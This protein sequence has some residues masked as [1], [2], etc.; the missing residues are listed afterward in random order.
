MIHGVI[1]KGVGGFYYVKTSEGVI[2]C[3]ARGNF[4]EENI[5][6]L[7]GDKV[8][9]RISSEDNT[10]Y[11]D[12]ILKRKSQLTRPAVANVTQAIIVMSI[13]NPDINTWLLDRFIVMAEHENLDIVIA[14]NKVD[15]DLEGA[16]EIKKIYENIGYKVLATSIEEEKDIDELRNTLKNNT[17]VFAGPSGVGKSSLLNLIE[18]DYDLEIGEIS[19]RSRRGKH[20]TRHTELLFLKENTYVLDTPGF[21]S[22]DIGFIEDEQDL[23]NYF[24]EIHDY[25]KYCKFLNCVHENEPGCEVKK[26]VENS[27]ISKE[28]YKNYLSFLEEIRKSR[29][30]RY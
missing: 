4:R 29:I 9:I 15:L 23:D 27:K 3:R 30:G 25:G 11:I 1:T 19:T 6:P 22:L 16:L 24:L 8:K 10:G 12:E 21:S 14:I 2:E 17:S 26:Q 20:T 28:R 5:T 7:I 13:K 18:P